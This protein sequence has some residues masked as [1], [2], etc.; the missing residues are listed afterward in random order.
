M[1]TDA[2]TQDTANQDRLAEQEERLRER[3]PDLT[4]EEVEQELSEQRMRRAELRF[5][6]MS[7]F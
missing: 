3:Q 6:G 5:A 4:D 1:S 2:Y 7:E